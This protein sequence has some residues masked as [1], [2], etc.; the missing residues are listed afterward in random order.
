MCHYEKR[1][2]LDIKVTN[3]NPVCR[4]YRLRKK[5]KEVDFFWLGSK[6][7]AT[8]GINLGWV[9]RE[10]P[11]H[12][13]ED[14]ETLLSPARRINLKLINCPGGVTETQNVSQMR[15]VTTY[16][17][18]IVIR[19]LHAFNSWWFMIQLC[20]FLEEIQKSFQAVINSHSNEWEQVALSTDCLHWTI[21]MSEEP[22]VLE[23]H[24]N[25]FRKWNEMEHFQTGQDF[26]IR[27]GNIT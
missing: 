13:G 2:L 14:P 16:T 1:V 9:N 21:N 25:L 6:L 8:V 27:L 23:M 15:L 17:I 26:T 22:P 10:L 19:I 11:C 4:D 7:D 18:S 24:L 5:K 12:P 20:L 3:D